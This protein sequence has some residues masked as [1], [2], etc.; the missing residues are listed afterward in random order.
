MATRRRPDLEPFPPG[1]AISAYS[2]DGH[3]QHRR[4]QVRHGKLANTGVL[5]ADG[6]TEDNDQRIAK[7]VLGALELQSARTTDVARKTHSAAAAVA[8]RRPR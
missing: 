8:R 4:G 5:D 2:G 3:G 1:G 7:G 6:E